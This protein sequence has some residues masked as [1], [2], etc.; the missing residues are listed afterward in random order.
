MT[1]VASTATESI[2]A[3]SAGRRGT[4]AGSFAGARI[5]IVGCGDVG[6][7][8]VAA[9]G[10]R[11]RIVVTTHS[12]SRVDALRRA[13]LLPVVADLDDPRTLG[14]LRGLA[15]TVVHLAPPPPEGEIDTRT[16]ALIDAIGGV[17]RFVYV[18]TSG[19]YGDCGG[20]WVDETRAVAPATGRARRRVDAERRLRTWARARGVRLAILRV[21]GIYAADRLPVA[22]IADGTPVLEPADD[23]YTNHVHADD[24]A[25]LI[26]LA[27]R[28]GAPQRV[29]HAVDDSALRMGDWFDRIAEAHGLP[30]PPRLPR[31]A[32]ER[33]VGPM[34]MS[35][36]RESRRLSNA[37]ARL[38]LG[39]RPRYPTVDDALSTPK[40]K[41]PPL[42]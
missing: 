30:R 22:R 35:F 11:F 9:L 29:Y 14:R 8:L 10:D 5:L 31:D 28:R 18:S 37:R 25:R 36:M 1:T 3:G 4:R 7:R 39:F 34:R 42:D 13:G 33:L 12:P 19:V 41:G 26:A 21:P 32:L 16:R 20:A 23:V 27:I 17:E 6:L 40:E 24:L 38:E 15:P 2:S